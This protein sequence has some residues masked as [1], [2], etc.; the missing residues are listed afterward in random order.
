ML[1]YIPSI[2]V[3]ILIGTAIFALLAIVDL[4][5]RGKQATRWREYLFLIL[6][7]ATALLYGIFN[8]QI[9]SSISWEYFYFGKDLARKLGPQTPPDALALH[10]QAAQIG[11]MATWTAGLIA[12]AAM[13]IANNPGALPR[14][15]YARLAARLPAFV[16]ITAAFG[17]LF[18]LAGRYYLLNWISEDF[19]GLVTENMWRP[20]HFMAVFGI[21]LGGYVGGIIGVFYCIWSIRR[22]RR[23]IFDARDQNHQ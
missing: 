2:T 19:R 4:R 5:Q 8:D 21:H 1:K 10:W 23:F 16:L 14:L 18:G 9:T 11:M 13:L 15:S 6:C 3:R 17:V 20:R 12:G 22:E 7:V